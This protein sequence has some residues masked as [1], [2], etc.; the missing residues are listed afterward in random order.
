MD[1]SSHP[2]LAFDKESKERKRGF[3]SGSDPPRRSE[4]FLN[5]KLSPSPLNLFF[6]FR[7]QLESSDRGSR[8]YLVWWIFLLFCWTFFVTQICGSS[9]CQKDTKKGVILW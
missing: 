3:P 7:D 2:G 9:Y 5:S 4:N 6:L 8:F 1:V